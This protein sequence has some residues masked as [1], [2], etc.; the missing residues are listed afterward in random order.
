MEN[1]F[2]IVL[3]NKEVF[4]FYEKSQLDFEHMNIVFV[5]ILKKLMTDLDSSVNSN[6]ASSLLNKFAELDNKIE[7]ITSSVSKCNNDISSAI[8]VKLNEYRKEYIE[9]LKQILTVNNSEYI[10]PLIKENNSALLDK[11]SLMI[12]DI[13]PKN[14]DILSKDI[15]SHFKLFQSAVMSETNKLVSSALDKKTIDDFFNNINQTM[16]HSHSTLLTLLTSSESRIENRLVETERKLNEIKEISTLNNSTQ[17][18]LYT[19]VSEMLKKFEKGITKGTV[20]EHI[21]YNILLSLFPCAQIDHVGGE[22]KETGDIILTRNNKPKILIENKDHISM[23]VPKT[24]VEKFIRDCEIQ[25]CCGIMLAQHRGIANKQNFELQI[26]NGNVLLYLH[27]VNFDKDKIKI[28][29]DII[30]QFKAK[31]DETFNNEDDCILD[32]DTLNEINREFVNY[33]TQK[34]NMVK[35]LRDFNEKMSF[36]INEIKMPSLEKYLSSKFATAS[37]QCE[38]LCKYCEKVVQKSLLQHYRY[39]QA[40]KDFEAA[41]PFDKNIVVSTEK[42]ETKSKSKSKPQTPP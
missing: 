23:N 30:E 4:E 22:Q 12:S 20:S 42:K 25:N 24:D 16:G 29:I 33:V 36:S 37:V 38:N 34:N 31:I 8:E 1:N 19:N 27:E 7:I 26:N 18:S 9:N 2:Q 11:T 13:I 5:N 3:N 40:K 21:V 41:P 28:A 10:A 6:L 35:L 39:C 32:K 17:Q 14:N 15:N